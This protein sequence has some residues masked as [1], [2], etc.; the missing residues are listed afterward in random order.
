MDAQTK[1]RLGWVQR[2]SERERGACCGVRGGAA[3]VF[4][5]DQV[6]QCAANMHD[7]AE[8]GRYRALVWATTSVA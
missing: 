1:A 3:C 6:Q 4:H 7:D 2:E 5:G 8:S